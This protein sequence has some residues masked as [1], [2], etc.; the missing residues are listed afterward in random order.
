MC[1]D[2]LSLFLCVGCPTV[3]RGD[4]GTENGLVATAQLAFHH[5]HVDDRA[6]TSFLYRRSVSNIVSGI[7]QGTIYY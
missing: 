6:R 7:D 3:V 5:M 4:H 2:L 1:P